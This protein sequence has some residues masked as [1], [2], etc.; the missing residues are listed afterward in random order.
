VHLL[1]SELYILSNGVCKSS[2]FYIV[3][4]TTRVHCQEFT[5]A[6][7]DPSIHR[8]LTNKWHYFK[9]IYLLKSCMT[10]NRTLFSVT[11]SAFLSYFLSFFLSFFLHF[12]FWIL[13]KTPGKI[14]L[15]EKYYGLERR[16]GSLLWPRYKTLIF[17]LVKP[18][19]S[20]TNKLSTQ[21]Y[22]QELRWS[23]LMISKGMSVVIWLVKIKGNLH[24]LPR[25]LEGLRY[26]I[27][28]TDP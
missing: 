16:L 19:A 3:Y 18:Q 8:L 10:E 7:A 1:A 26:P 4:I 15:L 27:R 6:K 28:S 9:Y 22:R 17:S 12:L 11:F 2:F 24:I 20:N 5:N 21:K 14:W 13:S 25:N 23:V